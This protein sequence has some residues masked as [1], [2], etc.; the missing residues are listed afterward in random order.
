[1]LVRVLNH[2]LF[3]HSNGLSM[4]IEK[5]LPKE[6]NLERPII[7]E[8]RRITENS[9]KL[10]FGEVTD[11]DKRKRYRVIRTPNRSST[12]VQ[13][14]EHVAKYRYLRHLFRNICCRNIYLF[15]KDDSLNQVF[16][17]Q[18]VQILRALL[19]ISVTATFSY[20]VEVQDEDV[21]LRNLVGE[22]TSI[23]RQ[24]PQLERKRKVLFRVPGTPE[25]REFVDS[26]GVFGDASI[27]ETTDTY[28]LRYT[29]NNAISKDQLNILIFVLF[30]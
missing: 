5:Y 12:F 11:E 26:L 28:L 13:I 7:D 10:T 8:L 23:D 17:N 9:V 20:S 29:V 4:E 3:P 15:Y 18:T 19:S 16:K 6:R 22:G 27:A 14:G 21:E 25:R 24:H 2:P 1:M 30:D